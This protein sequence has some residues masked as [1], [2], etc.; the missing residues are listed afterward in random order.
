MSRLP[1]R[2]LCDGQHPGRADR[3]GRER[4]RRAA[5]HGDR[6]QDRP[7]DADPQLQDQ[8]DH[9]QSVLERAGIDRPQ[10]HHSAD[11]QGSELS[12]QEQHPHSRAGRQR[13]R[14]D[15]DRLEHRGRGE[16]PLPPGSGLRQRHG[17]GEDQLPEPGRRLHARHAAAEPVLQA[18]ALRF[19]GLRARA[20]R[21]RPRHL[22]AARHAGLGP[23]AFRADDQE[24]REHAGRSRRAGAGL[25]HLHLGLVDGRRRRRI[26]AT[27]STAA[28][29]STNC[30]SAT[31]L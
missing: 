18:D 30:R 31:A 14:S 7:P 6:R 5:P 16:I 2:S 19:V 27:T 17:L 29:A 11:A 4:P 10:G 9:R 28:T 12:D 26:S 25:F 1:R 15:D 8:R 23:P 13:D 21:A 22:A 20:E 24:R 3:G